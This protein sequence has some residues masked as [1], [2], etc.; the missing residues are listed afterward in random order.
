MGLHTA[1]VYA[2]CGDQITGITGAPF[3]IVPSPANMVSPTPGS[4]LTGT[5]ATFTWAAAAGATG[6][7]L[8]VGTTAGA[9]NVAF[10][11]AG[12]QTSATVSGIPALGFTLYVTLYSVLQG[13]YQQRAYTYIESGGTPV[14][15]TMTSPTTGSTLS[16][17]SAT[18]QWT[19]GTAV[20]Q[21]TLYVGTTLGAHDIAF[22]NAGLQTSAT[23]NNIPVNGG[24]LYVTLYSLI[25]GSF[26]SHAYTY[27]EAGTPTP[28]AMTSPTSGSKLSGASVTFNWSAGTG[29]TQYT[30]YVGTRAGAYDVAFVNPGKNTSATV[31][32]VPTNGGTLFV[33]L[34]SLISG[35]F[36]ARSYTYIEAGTPAKATITSPTNGSSITGTS[37]T[38]SWTAGTGVTSYSLYVGTTAGAHDLAFLP[39]VLTSATVTNLPAS[40]KTIY[41]SLYS[42]IDGAWQSASYSYKN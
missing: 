27:T 9:H 1:Y 26:Q 4:Q 12:T 23:V 29:V 24:V 41:V 35:K 25:N 40:G 7:T 33:T 30:L 39:T 16:G 11:N 37:A 2:M 19:T 3:V 22:L 5:T 18:F 42:L 20:S 10:V 28:G 31:T 13:V 21:Y 17:S 34:N 8:Y 14:A 36:Q 6:Y 15:A 32:T 38:F